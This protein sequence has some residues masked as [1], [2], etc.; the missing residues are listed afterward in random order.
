MTRDELLQRVAGI[1][2]SSQVGDGE[3]LIRELEKGLTVEAV[4][5]PVANRPGDA[6]YRLGLAG[7]GLTASQRDALGKHLRLA[8]AAFLKDV[9]TGKR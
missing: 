2:R 6:F 4:E 3:G 8:T 5:E 7:V 9:I 1:I